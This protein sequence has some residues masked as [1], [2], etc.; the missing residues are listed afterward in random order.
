MSVVLRYFSAVGR[1]AWQRATDKRDSATVHHSERKVLAVVLHGL[2]GYPADISSYSALLA[3]WCALYCPSVPRGNR[4]TL[5]SSAAAIW[6]VV[7]RH[8]KRHPDGMLVFVGLSNGGRIVAQLDLWMRR[9]FPLVPA[10]VYTLVCPFEGTLCLNTFGTLGK[11]MGVVAQNVYDEM[12][13]YSPVARELLVG[14]RG[15]LPEGCRR[16]YILVAA[17]HDII[18]VPY[19]SA[20]PCLGHGEI[21][22]TLND[23]H[24]TAVLSDCESLCKLIKDAAASL[25][26]NCNT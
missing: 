9:N 11:M 4:Q 2:N 8:L 17:R 25:Q 1:L 14:L 24:V 12:R 16:R 23:T 6:P 20:I 15:A 13:Y 21:K 19:T 18:V 26:N 7:A 5:R 22:L 10:V 3:P